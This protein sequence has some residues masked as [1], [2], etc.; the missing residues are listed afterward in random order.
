MSKRGLAGI[1]TTNVTHGIQS[2]HVV[3]DSC[4]PPSLYVSIFDNFD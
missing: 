3:P 2:L 4:I 1:P